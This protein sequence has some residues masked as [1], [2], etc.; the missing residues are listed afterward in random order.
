MNTSFFRMR[1]RAGFL[2]GVFALAVSLVVS[3]CGGGSDSYTEPATANNPATP[4]AKTNVLIHAATLKGWIDEGLVANEGTFDQRV[5][6][7]DYE[8]GETKRIKGACKVAK[9]ALVT[10]R[11]EGVADASPLVATGEMMDAVIQNSG[12]DENTVIVFTT[13]SSHLYYET[14]AYWTFRYWGF[15]KDRLRVLDGGNAAFEEAYP[16]LM[17]EEESE[18][19]PS[20]YSVRDLDQVNTDLRASIGEL[21]QIFEGLPEDDTN[22]VIDGRGSA[23]YLGTKS[24]SGQIVAGDVVVVDGHPE[25][26]EFLSWAD[27]LTDGSFKSAEEIKALFEAKGWTPDKKVTVYCTSGFSCT[28]LFFALDAILD[29]PV[30]VHDA[31]WAQTGNY[32]DYPAAGGELPV[33]S[34]WAIDN[35][36]NCASL[37]Y[38]FWV[39]VPLTIEVLAYD[40]AQEQDHP[41]IGDDPNSDDDVNPA[42]NDI[43]EQDQADVGTTP[44][45][46]ITDPTSTSTIGM[47]V[48]A[49]TLESWMDDGLVNGPLGEERV[50]LLDVT[51]ST[52]YASG[53]LPGAQLWNTTQQV[54]TRLEGPAQ[55]VNMVVTADRMNDLIQEHGIDEYTTIVFTTSGHPIYPDRAYFLFRYYGW[56]KSRL[57][58]LD[59]NNGAWDPNDLTTE[60]P[61]IETSDLTVQAIGNLQP[62]V[63]VSLPELMDALRDG[64]G[65]AVDCRGDSTAPGTTT[66]VFAPSGDYVVFEGRPN[67]GT[68]FNWTDFLVNYANGDQRFKSAE[69]IRSALS[70]KGITASKDK[71]FTNP[72]YPYCRT[73]MIGSLGFFVFDGILGWDTMLYDGSWSQFGQLSANASKGGQLPVGSLWAVDNATYMEV[74]K[75]N[76]DNNSKIEPLNPDSEAL[77]INPFENP[78]NQV[79]EADSQYWTQGQGAAEQGPPTPVEG[80]VTGC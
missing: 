80:P 12:I 10:T 69:E 34:P 2:L 28:P 7:I 52:S 46:T 14:R 55:S 70:A 3:G 72:V 24:T 56:P 63:R 75:Y 30:Q 73:G 37:R 58:V 77:G 65:T 31:S 68:F 8:S 29:A 9:S 32:S 39:P 15:P 48:D 22:L 45:V 57:K 51:S 23:Y 1:N 11:F 26:G 20:T 74:V 38:N 76:A 6:I 43:E 27:L 49:L 59:G 42:A 61:T 16:D 33:G 50:V 35:Y 4:G 19:Q 5:V 44:T 25:G 21:L 36:L 66:G 40:V 53:H 79:E 78:P 54:E 71:G 41:F 60:T 47:L 64:R 67:N 13:S 18:A 62:Q 17:T